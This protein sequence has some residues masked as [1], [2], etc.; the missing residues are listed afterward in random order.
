[1]PTRYE[2]LT[3][4]NAL[5]DSKTVQLAA[6]GKTGRELYEIEDAV[7]NL[8]M[9]DSMGCIGSFWAWDGID[10]KRHRYCGG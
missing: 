4:I 9:V 5:K 6:T 3:V 2:A 1:M 10:P 8:Y 7:H